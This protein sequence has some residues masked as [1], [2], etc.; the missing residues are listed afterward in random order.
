[1]N[2]QLKTLLDEVGGNLKADRRTAD[3]AW[4]TARRQSRRARMASVAAVSIA[5]TLTVVVVGA[6]W[7]ND[8]T[9]PPVDKPSPPP[10]AEH[11]DIAPMDPALIQ[12]GWGTL[13]FTSLPQRDTALPSVLNL[14]EIRASAVPLADDPV[15]RAIAVVQDGRWN[16]LYYP[17]NRSEEE[18]F[19]LGDDGRWRR[20]TGEELGFWGK[21]D[22]GGLLSGRSLS[23]D[24]TRFA[25][26]GRIRPVTGETSSDIVVV[27][28]TTGD[29]QRFDAPDNPMTPQ[30]TPD[31]TRLI[32]AD[33]SG[34]T[35]SY[36][37]DLST[38]ELSSVPYDALAAGFSTSGE[39]VEMNRSGGMSRPA[40]L[41]RFASDGSVTTVPIWLRIADDSYQ[42]EI[43]EVAAVVRYAPRPDGPG[44]L[45][46]D[47][48]TGQ[49][50][51][52][53]RVPRSLM[54]YVYPDGWLDD[55]TVLVESYTQRALVSW[56]YRTGELERVSTY[57]PQLNVD[58][59]I[60]L[61]E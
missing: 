22:E 43:G 37:L 6:S 16:D 17:T 9:T 48:E 8:S 29:Q 54:G 42:P 24:G 10:T 55:D 31:G 5:T 40:E 3:R 26:A 11:P 30:W 18:V 14:D 44:I 33:L 45:V 7:S 1:M 34:R 53:L 46:F 19:F 56:N 39:P 59:A 41:R 52:Q 47:P 50:L 57:T 21:P 28:L 27:D 13:D 38:G 36:E 32:I 23:P 61:L 60:D 51:A 12:D 25:A 20:L 58:Y 49:P 15:E 4:E 35:G 2:E